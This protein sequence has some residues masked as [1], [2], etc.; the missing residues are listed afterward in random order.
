MK[1][2]IAII[3]VLIMFCSCQNTKKNDSKPQE[4][5]KKIYVSKEISSDTIFLKNDTILKFN[6][7]SNGYGVFHWGVVNEFESSSKD[8]LYLDSVDRDL[9]KIKNSFILTN[10]CGTACTYSLIMP[11]NKGKEEMT[12]MYP[13]IKDKDSGYLVAKGDDKEVLLSIIDLTNSKVSNVNEE[14]DRTKIP[15]SLAIDTVYINNS[16]LS[17][18]WYDKNSKLNFRNI[19]LSRN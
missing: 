3:S 16:K 2:Y 19:D 13:L 1:N 4:L 5:E 10:S 17:F 12:V 11:I 7:K 6:S 18:K 9:V 14:F 8:S 15:P